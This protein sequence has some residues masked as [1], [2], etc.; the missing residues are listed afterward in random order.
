MYHALTCYLSLLPFRSRRHL[1]K[2][3][4]LVNDPA[5]AAGSLY[6]VAEQGF[7]SITSMFRLILYSGIFAVQL[8]LLLLDAV[9]YFCL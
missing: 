3:E 9:L 4:A 7:V 6:A 5:G 1:Q 8:L 2:A